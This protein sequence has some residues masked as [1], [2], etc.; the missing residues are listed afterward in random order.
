MSY[1]LPDRIIN[2]TLQEWL[3]SNQQSP[4]LETGIL[5]IE[6]HSY[7]SPVRYSTGA[8][9]HHPSRPTST[10]TVWIPYR[11]CCQGRIRTHED[12]FIIR[13]LSVSSRS[14]HRPLGHLTIAERAGLE[15]TELLSAS[16]G[17][18]IPCSTNYA[19]LSNEFAGEEGLEPPTLA[20]TAPSS[21]QL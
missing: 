1:N 15:P 20:L 5:P 16:K 9:S 18:A 7:I 6:L 11:H 13:L 10:S 19:Y 4:V 2:N 12:Y 3:G 17:L 21:D 14:C 8:K